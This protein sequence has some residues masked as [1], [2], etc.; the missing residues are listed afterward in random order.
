M[1]K[2]KHQLR[3]NMQMIR[4]STK[5]QKAV[6]TINIEQ[7]KLFYQDTKQFCKNKA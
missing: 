5:Y 2:T 7:E 4:K 1:K 6:E 3:S